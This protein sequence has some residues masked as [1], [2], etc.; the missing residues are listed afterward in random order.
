M[1]SPVRC[2]AYLHSKI[3]HMSARNNRRTYLVPILGASLPV[4]EMYH[5]YLLQLSL[6]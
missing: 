1:A 2:P 5:K 4:S 6:K 3:A